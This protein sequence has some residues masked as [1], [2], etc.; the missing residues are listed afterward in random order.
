MPRKAS[1]EQRIA[2]HVAHRDHCGCRPAPSAK[3]GEGHLAL[4]ANRRGPG[5]IVL[6]SWWGLTDATRGICHRLAKHGF[7]AIAP[8]LYRGRLARTAAEARQLRSARRAEPAFR[9]IFEARDALLAHEAV[10]GRRLG[11]LGLSMGGHWALWLGSRADSSIAATVVFYAARASSF[12]G[13][14]SAAYQIHLA[15]HDDFVSPAGV[16]RMQRALAAA[17]RPTETHTYP[18]TSHWFFESDQPQFDPPAARLAWKRT[19]AFLEAQLRADVP[20]PGP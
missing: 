16:R 7:V 10:V 17:G 14:P 12:A 18:G 9:T 11:V 13:G 6:H 19:L 20:A 5:V 4:P 2:W 8:D 1:L 3:G 15:E